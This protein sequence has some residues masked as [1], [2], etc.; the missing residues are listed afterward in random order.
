M[1]ERFPFS[2]SQM[3]M[4]KKIR[5]LAFE[6]YHGLKNDFVILDILDQE[7]VDVILTGENL[8]KLADRKIGIGCD[9]IMVVL[10]AKKSDQVTICDA[11]YVYKK[12]T[13]M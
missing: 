5:S 6:K 11:R 3:E 12:C 2:Y 8:R 10:P 9:Q 7:Q 1:K 13:C 4:K